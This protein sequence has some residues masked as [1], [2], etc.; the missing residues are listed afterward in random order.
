MEAWQ[1]CGLPGSVLQYQVSRLTALSLVE[2]FR[3]ACHGLALTKD[4]R[5]VPDDPTMKEDENHAKKKKKKVPE[6][7]SSLPSAC[8]LVNP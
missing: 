5:Y 8:E 6:V 7:P 4:S 3:S 1:E 2:V